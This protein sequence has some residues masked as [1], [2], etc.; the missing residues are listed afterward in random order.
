MKKVFYISVLFI[1]NLLLCFQ[2]INACTAP[3]VTLRNSFISAKYVFLG[4]IVSVERKEDEELPEKLQDYYKA[5]DK[6]T[7]KVIKSWKGSSK[8][9]IVN[10]SIPYCPCP[11]REFDF[12]K[13]KKFLVF[14]DENNFF[15]ICDM[16]SVQMDSEYAEYVEKNIKR[17]NSFWF[18]TWARIYPF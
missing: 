14:A 16:N 8:N 4:E 13:G 5:L 2:S 3:I 12:V 1:L 18:R 11:G 6:I 10:Y 9:Q 15:D 17:L 7:F